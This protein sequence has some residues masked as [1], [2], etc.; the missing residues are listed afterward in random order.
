MFLIEEKERNMSI[1][2]IGV[3]LTWRIVLSSSSMF[4]KIIREFKV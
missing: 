3:A 2:A 1:P 4:L